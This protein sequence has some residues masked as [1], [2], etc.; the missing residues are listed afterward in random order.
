MWETY[1]SMVVRVVR[2]ALTIGVPI[3]GDAAH[4]EISSITLGGDVRAESLR[5]EGERAEISLWWD[6]F[7]EE[8]EAAPLR[9]SIGVEGGLFA[10]AES[11]VVPTQGSEFYATF[12]ATIGAQTAAPEPEMNFAESGSFAADASAIGV[13]RVECLV[14]SH[15][16]VRVRGSGTFVRA[17]GS[18]RSE[19]AVVVIVLNES[20]S[21]IAER[22]EQGNSGVWSIGVDVPVAPG[23]YSVY[24]EFR[25]DALAESL[26]GSSSAGVE[27]TL[28]VHALP[29]SPPRCVGDADADGVVG[30][31]DLI[32]VLASFDFDY[33]GVAA[34]GD[35]NLDGHV[36]FRDIIATLTHFSLACP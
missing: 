5:G 21:V 6:W 7:E 8:V 26:D 17:V 36:N 23:A 10:T 15:G 25:G 24:L 2:A 11:S 32:E 16:W 19:S 34:A 27:G 14:R 33:G 1:E 22:I 12:V 18:G 13:A 20:G 30:F 35:S 9:C 31:S 28:R 3:V 29:G 4:A